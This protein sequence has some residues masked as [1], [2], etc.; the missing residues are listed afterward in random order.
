MSLE[1]ILRASNLHLYSR[2]GSGV[3]EGMGPLG[4]PCRGYPF[5]LAQLPPPTGDPRV[6]TPRHRPP[7]PLLS[8][9]FDYPLYEGVGAL[10]GENAISRW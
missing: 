4:R 10:E 6:S 5:V 8:C 9:V 2:G 3:D 7:P 1:G